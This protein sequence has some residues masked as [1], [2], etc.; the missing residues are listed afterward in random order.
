[1]NGPLNSTIAY[2]NGQ[3]LIYKNGQ[4]PTFIISFECHSALFCCIETQIIAV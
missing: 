2:V 3:P 1:M 4:F